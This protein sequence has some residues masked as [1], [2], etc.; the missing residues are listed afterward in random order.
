MVI[1]GGLRSTP[2]ETTAFSLFWVVQR[3]DKHCN[4]AVEFATMSCSTSLNI[5]GSKK[6][7]SVCVD[8]D[9]MPAIP[10]MFNPKALPK[11]TQL[12]VGEDRE[13][14]RI[15]DKD[16]ADRAKAAQA[17]AKAAAAKKAKK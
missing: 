10:M 3:A 17:A 1:D 8:D 14:K 11:G 16:I 13:A 15:G 5:P 9:E 7:A 12:L 4:M 6:R 2:Q